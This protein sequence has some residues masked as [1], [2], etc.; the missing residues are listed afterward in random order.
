MVLGRWT[1]LALAAMLAGCQSG[2]MSPAK[3]GAYAS[4]ASPAGETLRLKPAKINY[5]GLAPLTTTV[6]ITGGL[7]PYQAKQS[8]PAVADLSPVVR[9]GNRRQFSLTLIAGGETDVTV[10]DAAKHSVVLPAGGMP[11]SI[12]V[13]EF[14]QLYPKPGSTRVPLNVG[15]VF[16]ADNPGDPF[17]K[18]GTQYYV[19]LISEDGWTLRGSAFKRTHAGAPKGSAPGTPVWRATFSTLLPGLQYSVQ[20][21]DPGQSCE[22]PWFTGTFSTQ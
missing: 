16:M 17:R 14:V 7:P 12:P 15:E 1:F 13:T 4:I 22:S 8:N 21:V 3:D 2:G 5:S 20:F 11:C 18:F 10:T 9:Q 19:R 6:T